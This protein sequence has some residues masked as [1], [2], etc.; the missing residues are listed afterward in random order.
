M[1]AQHAQEAGEGAGSPGA[2]GWFCDL[3]VHSTASDGT[4]LPQ[5]LPKLARAAGLAAMALTDHDTTD[6]LPACAAAAARIGLTF[7]PGI[8][9]SADPGPP[10]GRPATSPMRLG[11]LHI[12]GLFVAA[13][14]A[15]LRQIRQR[16]RAAR[17]SRN[18][19]IVEKLNALGVGIDY[20]EVLDL[21]RAEGTQIIGRPHIAEVLMRRGYADSVTD[22]FARYLR[23]GAPAYVR[24]DR[25]AAND[26]IDA[27]HHAG[28]LAVMAHPV[29]L[30][31]GDRDQLEQH[32][33]RLKDS[34]LDGIETRH[35]DHTPQE[36]D[37]FEDLAKRYGLGT[38][39]GSDF[40]GSR[41]S[42]ALGSQRVPF[43]VFEGLVERR[44]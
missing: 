7:V 40:H 25:L 33:R 43:T 15:K 10:P 22:A 11:T 39:G 8:E 38:S 4:T 36:V 44:A 16:M 27:I 1:T 13:G 37:F 42:V 23:Q 21:A 30:V 32:V 18:P 35:S 19:A 17:N 9:I 5:D 29:Q 41:K 34:G 12:L 28:G 14:D 6:G 24:R 31:A 26:A 3:H 2:S 20:A